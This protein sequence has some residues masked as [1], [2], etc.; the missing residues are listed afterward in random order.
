[1]GW[2]D[3]GILG[4]PAKETPHLDQMAAEGTLMTDFYAAN[5]LCSPCKYS[6]AWLNPNLVPRVCQAVTRYWIR[7]I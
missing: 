1:M 3:L 2:G 5:P 6:D 7:C 4:Q